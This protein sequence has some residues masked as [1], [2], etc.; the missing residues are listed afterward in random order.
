MGG[1]KLTNSFGMFLEIRVG[2]TCSE[3]ILYAAALVRCI[4]CLC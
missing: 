2:A 3:L 1:K 4:G